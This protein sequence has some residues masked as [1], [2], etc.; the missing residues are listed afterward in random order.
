MW[1]KTNT[2][3][4][5]F[6]YICAYIYTHTYICNIRHTQIHTILLKSCYILSFII[7]KINCTDHIQ[8]RQGH[9]GLLDKYFWNIFYPQIAKI[10]FLAQGSSLSSQQ[11]V[12]HGCDTQNWQKCHQLETFLLWIIISV[13]LLRSETHTFI[14]APS[15]GLWNFSV[16]CVKTH[17]VAIKSHRN[18]HTAKLW[19]QLDYFI[20]FWG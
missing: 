3:Y 1:Y 10:Y 4:I 14:P 5:I 15:A 20:L 18:N 17:C 7:Y 13:P 11:A 19:K 8:K 12:V 2:T 6:L 9:F 16:S